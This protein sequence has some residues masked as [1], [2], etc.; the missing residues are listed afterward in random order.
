MEEKEFSPEDLDNLFGGMPFEAVEKKT[1]ENKSI[2]RQER[3]E[4]LKRDA[5]FNVFLFSSKYNFA[6]SVY[7]NNSSSSLFI[8]LKLI[9]SSYITS[10]GITPIKFKE[11]LI[12]IFIAFNR[13]IL[14]SVYSLSSVINLCAP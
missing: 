9:L 1:E 5:V 4:D 8:L 10:L 14:S 11:L 2:L 3:I 13:S 12:T 6:I 7:D